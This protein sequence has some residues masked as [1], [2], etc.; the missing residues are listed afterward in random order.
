MS[1]NYLYKIFEKNKE[2]DA[3][4]WQENT[5]SY[6]YLYKLVK[7]QKK[8]MHDNNIHQGDVVTIE[9]DYS[10]KSIATFIALIDIN[11]IIVPRTNI[12]S[13][14][15]IECRKIAQANKCI[16]IDSNDNCSIIHTGIQTSQNLLLRFSSFFIRIYRKNKSCSP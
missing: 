10:P 4:C 12:P 15:I 8:W 14:K 9:S 13:D 11:A 7:K 16:I 1:L 3:I 2:K 5:Y 6:D